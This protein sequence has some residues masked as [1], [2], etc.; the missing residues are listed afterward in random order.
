MIRETKFYECDDTED[1]VD[2]LNLIKHTW[3]YGRT[4]ID[5]TGDYY[6]LRE[7][8]KFDIEDRVTVNFN[9]LNLKPVDDGVEIRRI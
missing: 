2:V 8:M 4:V 7:P 3:N 9:G 1:L 5:L 6:W